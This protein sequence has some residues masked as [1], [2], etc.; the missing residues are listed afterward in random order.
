MYPCCAVT[1]GDTDDTFAEREIPAD[2]IAVS[3]IN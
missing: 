2:R 3:Y 1:L